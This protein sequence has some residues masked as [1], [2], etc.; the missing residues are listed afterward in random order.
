MQRHPR[1]PVMDHCP[2]TLPAHAYYDAGWYQQEMRT[3]WAKN[4][5]WRPPRSHFT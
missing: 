5:V 4:W 2:M 1:S 3:I